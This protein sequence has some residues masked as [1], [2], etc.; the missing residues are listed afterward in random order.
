MVRICRMFSRQPRGPPEDAGHEHGVRKGV[1]RVCRSHT[2]LC[3]RGA[4]NEGREGRE[5]GPVALLTEKNER[6]VR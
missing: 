3:S 2:Q 5:G 1:M 4:E 6:D